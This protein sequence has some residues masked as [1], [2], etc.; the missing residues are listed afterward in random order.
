M[1]HIVALMLG[2]CCLGCL[3]GC[4]GQTFPSDFPKVYPMTVTVKD[5]ATPLP[6]VS[7]MF[8]PATTGAGAAYA[9]SG[10]T[11]ANGVAKI[12]TSQGAFNRAGIPTGEFVVTVEDIIEVDLGVTPA[13]ETKMSMRELGELSRKK[14]KLI[15]AYERKVPEI[16]RRSG[17]VED[18]SPIRFTASEGKNELTIDV[19]EFKK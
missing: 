7:I 8:Y 12:S 4:G 3:S 16:L 10:S 18:R 13:E 9:S 17:K 19:A 11:N 15:A 14:E 1:K 2:T 5:G 6:K